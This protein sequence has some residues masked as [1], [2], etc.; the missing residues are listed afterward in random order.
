MFFHLAALPMSLIAGNREPFNISKIEGKSNQEF[1]F[2]CISED[3]EERPIFS[4]ICQFIVKKSFIDLFGHVIIERVDNF[5]DL[6]DNEQDPFKNDK[7][8]LFIRGC[9]FLEDEN[10]KQ[11][12]AEYFKSLADKGN[13]QSMVKYGDM[14]RKGIEIEADKDQA[15][16][17][18][19]AAA[20]KNNFKL[21]MFNYSN[22]IKTKTRI[23]TLF[24][25]CNRR[26]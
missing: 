15:E 26:R 3:P 8:S 16:N 22:L 12:A 24:S 21:G 14:V 25:T 5:F 7:D 23:R 6:F 10:L 1:I 17:Y 13:V 11:E 9:M 20:D 19:K 4:E 2:L 18:Y